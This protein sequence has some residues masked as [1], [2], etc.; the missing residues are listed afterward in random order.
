MGVDG[1][2]L[3]QQLFGRIPVA[4]IRRD[5]RQQEHGLGVTRL[6]FENRHQQR[7]GFVGLAVV[8][9]LGG[10]VE[11]PREPDGWNGFSQHACK[12]SASTGMGTRKE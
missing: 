7:P 9:K 2:G 8:V 4:G 5:R 6:A 10:S 3:L 11:G 12:P 1:D